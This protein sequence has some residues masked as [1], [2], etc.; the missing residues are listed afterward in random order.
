MTI[1]TMNCVALLTALSV[2]APVSSRAE[3]PADT[4]KS[5]IQNYFK[6]WNT[7]D[8]A[9]RTEL[10][11]TA[12]SE[13]GI[14]TDPSAHVEGRKALIDHI[15]KTLSSPQFQ[16]ASL[17]PASEIDLHNQV[18]RFQWKLVDSSGNKLFAGMDYGEFDDQ[19]MITKIIG[20]FGPFPKLEQ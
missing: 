9:K 19:G 7:T 6:A 12:W 11:K 14:Y 18:F 5:S 15:S 16:G 17:A 2:C 10:L 8:V 20:F 1:R 4:A 13:T 3:S